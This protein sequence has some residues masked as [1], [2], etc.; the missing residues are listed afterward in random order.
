MGRDLPQLH[1]QLQTKNQVSIF[2]LLG[3]GGIGKTEL[4]LQYAINY[5]NEYPGGLCWLEARAGDVGSRLLSFARIHLNLLIPEGLTFE[6]QVGYCW[7]NW[8]EGKALIIFDD[9]Q[10]YGA[11][12]PY[13]PPSTPKF[14]VLLTSRKRLGNNVYSLPLAVLTP[15]AAL[16]LLQSLVSDGRISAELEQAQSLCQQLGY[17]PLA[18]ELVGRYLYKSPTRTISQVR[19]QLDSL[20]LA[21]E[22][23]CKHPQDD[24][25][26]N[27]KLGVA[28]AFELSWTILS[29]EA[30]RLGCRLSLFAATPFKWEW[31]ETAFGENDAAELYGLHLLSG[32]ENRLFSL[33]PLIRE[34]FAM[35][36]SELP[37]REIEEDKCPFCG[38]MVAQ[39]KE[40]PQTLTVD[41]VARV[42]VVIPH[43]EVA[44]N[45]L[46]DVVEDEDTGWIF[47]GL[48]NYYK[49]QGLYQAAEPWYENCLKVVKTRLGDN[50]PDVVTSLNNLA[51]LYDSQGRYTEA[52]PLLQ[53]A[54][55]LMQQLDGE[56]HPHV[57]TALNNL[58]LL[59]KSQGRY[60]EAEPL[61][62]QALKLRQ[63]LLGDNHLNVAIT[64]NNLAGL[65]DSQG[66]YTEAEP[67][68]QQA[69]ALLQQL[70]GNNHPHVATS[71]NNL[72]GLY[73][74]QG[75]YTEAELLYQQALKIMQQLY[76]DNHPDVAQSL[77]NLALL[78]NAQGNYTEAEALSQ[79]A[80]TIFQQTLGNQHPHTQDALLAVKISRMQIL[81]HCDRQTLVSHLQALAQRAEIPEFN[82]EVALAM[83]EALEN[84]PDLLSEL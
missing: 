2:A 45:N 76:G 33:H 71:L 70:D 53:K 60:T 39:A 42:G 59:Y 7:R 29:P 31:V 11:I 28:A 72:A 32:G 79:Q 34:F 50:H 69:L 47:W 64:L 14:K 61:Y 49:E 36:L 15:E 58:A 16:E 43:L 9:V 3:I 80:L 75:R 54:L 73:R 8:V 46:M 12:K 5:Q 82:P 13:L 23:L 22:A 44:A 18:I 30:Q 55:K 62:L 66:R 25:D 77:N 78:Y 17:L 6:Q 26:M 48:G 4:A 10:E 27:A 83:L 51:V 41:E 63:Q 65:Y 57:A 21:A 37:E 84:N 56:N 52:E 40:I 19:Q 67:L 35:K 38:V 1:Q 81:L 24:E 20:R 74:S 68:L